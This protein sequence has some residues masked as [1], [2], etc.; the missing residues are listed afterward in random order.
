M[1]DLAQNRRRGGGPDE[2]ARIFVVLPHIGARQGPGALRGPAQGRVRAPEV[3]GSTNPSRS[4]TSVGSLSIV[5][6]RPA[7][8]RRTRPGGIRARARSSL[9]PRAIV[10]VEIPVARATRPCHPGRGRAPRSRPTRGASAPSASPPAPG[11]SRDKPGGPLIRLYPR[12]AQ[13]PSSIVLRTISYVVTATSDGF[14]ASMGQPRN[15]EAAHQTRAAE[16]LDVDSRTGA[17][18]APAGGPA[19]APPYLRCDPPLRVVCP[20]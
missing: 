1:G 14:R 16:A 17:A 12:L 10:E 11:I 5:R 7:P 20:P 2:R 9:S 19:L 6:F 8:G 15:L 18:T 4:R 3:V 13:T